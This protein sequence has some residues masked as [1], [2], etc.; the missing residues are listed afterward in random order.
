MATACLGQSRCA[1]SLS[2][3]AVLLTL[4]V[5]IGGALSGTPD[6]DSWRS[7]YE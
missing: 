7:G 3:G 6:L 5:S 1:S 2:L 4:L